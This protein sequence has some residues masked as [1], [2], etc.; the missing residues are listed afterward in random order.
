M[1]NAFDRESVHRK[2]T[3]R[4]AWTAVAVIGAA[5]C[6]ALPRPGAAVAQQAF[7]TGQFLIAAPGMGPWATLA[8]HPT[9][10][11]AALTGGHLMNVLP[12]SLIPHSAAQTWLRD[13]TLPAWKGGT[14]RAWL[15]KR[16]GKST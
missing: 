4:G 12:A 15:K 5:C 7:L 1:S 3:S 6:A 10:W 2:K 14:F 11:S 13:R 8:T 9:L 16:R